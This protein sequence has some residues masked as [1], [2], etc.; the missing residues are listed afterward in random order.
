MLRSLIIILIVV[1]CSCTTGQ[2]Q[3]DATGVET[4]ATVRTETTDK[5]SFNIHSTTEC[6]QTNLSNQFDIAI[7]LKRYTDAIDHRDSCVLKAF[8]KEKHSK[9]LID[10][11][12][13]T[14]LYYFDDTF[15]NCDSVMSFTTKFNSQR[16]VVD[17][18]FGDI[19]IADLNFDNKDDIAIIKDYGGNGGTF[20]S[21]FI[22]GD[23]KKF[24]IDSFL[25]DSV[26]YFPSII[27]QSK[28]RL[29]TYVHA[30][31]CCVGEHVYKF[32]KS[33]KMWKQT[34]HKILGPKSGT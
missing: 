25:T 34:R 31:A 8:I 4:T 10:S 11:F 17:N 23:N 5:R 32:D 13:I 14:S 22:Q 26:T 29:I 19:V 12:I 1:F 16:Q 28:Q 3:K 2:N 30:G 7:N 18:Y 20:Y 6:E 27:D 33:T 21:Y 24:T 9:K 15:A